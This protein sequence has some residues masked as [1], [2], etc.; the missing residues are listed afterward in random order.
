MISETYYQSTILAK[1]KVH[2]LTRGVVTSLVGTWVNKTHKRKW[3]NYPGRSF[4]LKFCIHV[5]SEPIYWGEYLRCKKIIRWWYFTC[6]N[7]ENIIC[8]DILHV[9]MFHYFKIPYFTCKVFT[10][11]TYN[12]WIYWTLFFIARCSTI[13][14]HW[15]PRELLS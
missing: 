7:H 3:S 4:L 11:F 2:Q 1:V 13:F 8:D 10:K 9:N 6:K 5:R 14:A 15:S 12:I